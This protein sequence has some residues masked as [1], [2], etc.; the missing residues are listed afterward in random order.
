MELIPVTSSNVSAIGYDA[1][2]QTLGIKFSS[3]T[4]YHYAGV[5][6]DV[7]DD[8]VNAESIGRFFA[9]NIRSHYEHAKVEE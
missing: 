6:K 7:Y 8:F 3:G 1:D 9:M 4:V 5:P 2:T